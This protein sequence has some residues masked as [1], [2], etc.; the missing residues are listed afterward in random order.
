MPRAQSINQNP[1]PDALPNCRNLGVVL[2]LVLLLNAAAL[3]LAVARAISWSEIGELWLASAALLEPVLLTS[4]L[5]LYGLQPRLDTL[6]Y[7]NGVAITIL[8]GCV[9]TTLIYLLGA[10]VYTPT[11]EGLPFNALRYALLAGISCWGSLAYFRLR[12]LALSPALHHARLQALRARIR[13]HFLFNTLNA[14]LAIVRSQPRRAE[15]ALEDLSDLFRMAMEDAADRVPLRREL[16]LARRYLALEQLRL[17]E[18]LQ[19]DWR[20]QADVE[21]AL[22][23]PLLL[24][25][26]LENAIYHGIER[27]PQGGTVTISIGRSHRDLTLEI[28]NPHPGTT[29]SSGHRLALDNIRERL[30]LLYDLEANY[31]VYAGQHEYRVRITLPYQREE[32]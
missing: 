31:Q 28:S 4:L 24:Q 30:A 26:V 25:P 10:P 8:L 14:V 9:T 1:L 21:S 15:E 27:L 5:A 7:R 18:R 11:G 32:P 17:G 19:L 12:Q 29:G 6:P 13:P 23:P 22:I 20:V 16:E 3:L 2:R